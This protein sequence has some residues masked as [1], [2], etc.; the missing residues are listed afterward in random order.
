MTRNCYRN[1]VIEFY[2]RNSSSVLA[3]TRKHWPDS[4]WTSQPELARLLSIEVGWKVDYRSLSRQFRRVQSSD[5]KVAER[6][7]EIIQS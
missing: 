7:L 4:V 1:L 3:M 5:S 6:I 2:A